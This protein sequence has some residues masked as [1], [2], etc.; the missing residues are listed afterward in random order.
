MRSKNTVLTKFGI[1]LYWLALFVA[2]L[3]AGPQ[4]K[5]AFNCAAGP[6]T[7]DVVVFDSPTIFNRLGAQNPNYIMYALKRDVVDKQI[8]PVPCTEA[9]NTCSAGNVELR[10]DKRPRPLVVRSVAG[11]NLTVTFTNWLTPTANPNNAIDDNPPPFVGTDAVLI[12]ND[13]VAGRCAGFHASGTELVTGMA[14]DGS[15]VGANAGAST[16]DS[17][18]GAAGSCGTAGLAAPDETRT[19]NLHTPHEGAFIINSHG[20]RLG[21]EGNA[22]N[23]GL[24]MFG[25]LNVQPKNTA[26]M[27]RS[28]VTEEELRLATT[29]FTPGGQPIIDY[30]AAYPD[31]LPWS[32]EG[33]GGKPILNMLDGNALFHSDINAIIV[34]SGTNG[35][36][37][38][39]TYPLESTG[40]ANNPQLPNRLEPFREFTSIYHD[41]QTNAQVYPKWYADPVLKHTIHGVRDSFMINYGSGGIGSEIISN[42]LHTG[43]MHDC[44]DCAYEEFFLAASSSATRGKL[45]CLLAASRQ[46]T[47]RAGATRSTLPTRRSA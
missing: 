18:S 1:W 15:M 8:P 34:G 11:C 26:G 45:W 23:L 10:P 39:S 4:A 19:Y 41:E 35:S 2:T 9:G 5:A 25:A 27:Y 7:A 16:L 24:G 17:T 30:E 43:P 42:R 12:S 44:T 14:D 22:G 29:G 36:F 46:R 13:Q 28:Q 32:A 38:N 3:A 33:K 6:I 31:I 37:P 21:S 20:A 47:S 40:T